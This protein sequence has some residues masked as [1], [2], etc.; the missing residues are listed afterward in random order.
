MAPFRMAVKP[1]RLNPG[2]TVGVVAPASAPPDAA[3]IDLS[4]A[5]LQRLGFRAKLASHARRRW[6]FLAGTDRE[7]AAD[8]MK[9]FADRAVNGIVC[10]RGGYGTSRL[11]GRLDYQVIRANPKV[12]VGYSDITSLHCAFLKRAGLVS[13]HG[14]MLNSDFVHADFPDFT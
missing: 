11:L 12:F 9:M 4:I 7:R 3:T 5:V 1:P 14:P 2:D 10:V 8:L 6:G 13:F